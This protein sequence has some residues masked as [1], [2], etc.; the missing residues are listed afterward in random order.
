MPNCLAC[1]RVPS[2]RT[3][4]GFFALISQQTDRSAAETGRP[5]HSVSDESLEVV[6]IAA[7]GVASGP[8]RRTMALVQLPLPITLPDHSGYVSTA[9]RTL[10]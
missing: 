8:L 2:T 9:S 5:E 4:W 1:L 6:K 3:R 7:K 10:L